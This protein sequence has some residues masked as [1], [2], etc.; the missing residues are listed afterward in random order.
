MPLRCIA[1]SSVRSPS[2]VDRTLNRGATVLRGQR[3]TATAC[4][5]SSSA[6]S[7]TWSSRSDKFVCCKG[8]EVVRH[9]WSPLRRAP[10]IKRTHPVGII[11][12][13]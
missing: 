8:P 12:A 13:P 2:R 3:T 11:G 9:E 10:L 6:M 1:S 4:R 5:G 7:V